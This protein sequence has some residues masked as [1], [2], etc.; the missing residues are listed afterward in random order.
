[1]RYTIDRTEKEILIRLPLDSTPEAV[2]R[3]LD[4][5][6]YVDLG[7]ESKI[8][9][10]AIDEMVSESKRRWWQENKERFRGQPGFE[11]LFE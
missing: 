7:R 11:H 5:I 8:Q 3:A 4:F 9:Q 1:M 2:Q 6:R 10:A